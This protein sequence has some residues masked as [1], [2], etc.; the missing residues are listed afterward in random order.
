MI[1]RFIL[2]LLIISIPI[3]SVFSSDTPLPGLRGEPLDLPDISVLGDFYGKIDDDNSSEDGF[4]VRSIELAF[5]GYIYPEMRA[6]I[7]LAMHRHEDALE[8]ELCE[9]YVSFLKVLGGLSM[10]MGKV[11][12]DFG[13]INRIHQHER[14]SV[15]Q[16]AVITNFLGDHGLVGEGLDF[17]YLLPL[18]V[19]LQVDIGAWKIPA[20][21]H[22]PEEVTSSGN[23]FGLAEN[24]C[25]GRIWSSFSTGNYSE[26]ELGLSGAKGK[27]S[28]YLHHLDESEVTGADVTFRLWIS[29]FK[30]F[31]FQGE[32]LNL[33]R[34]VPPGT[35]N[36]Q[37]FYSYLGY[38]FSKYWETGLRYDNTDNAFPTNVRTNL[39]SAVV[40]K[41]LTETTKL[42]FQYGYEPD[43]NKSVAYFQTVFG[44]GPHSHP[45][46]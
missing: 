42:R 20:H 14:P 4:Y 23:E 8:P 25:T 30:R 6:D 10:K 15:D 40:T 31:I 35:L 7:F 39:I 33:T 38:Q 19:F 12:V 45:L 22:D 21:T 37:G 24:V 36:R 11:H 18:P 46:Q 3:F 27:G 43:S 32:I 9:G 17:S 29:S 34:T 2:T 41:K 26:F 44:I 28:H 13:K 1:K 5:Q 16:P